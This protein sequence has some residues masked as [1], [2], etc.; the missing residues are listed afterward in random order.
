MTKIFTFC[1]VL[2]GK[3]LYPYQ[4][5]FGKRLVRS[6]IENDGDEITGLMSRQSG[7]CFAKN[8]EILM[9][10]GE[11]KKVQDIVVGDFIMSPHS[12][13]VK[14][15]EVIKGKEE[16]FA[17]VS[18][19]KNHEDFIVNKSHTLSVVD[20]K[21]RVHNFTVEDYLKLPEWK[22][23]YE[24]RGYRVA[25][26]FKE[27]KTPIEPYF[28]GLWL[29]D[30]S[31]YDVKITSVDKEVIDYIYDY[32]D[33]LGMQVSI[34][35]TKT[36]KTCFDYAITNGKDGT[37]STIN[38]IRHYLE[39]NNLLGNKHITK[40]FLLNSRKVRL[41]VLAGLID[42]D[43]HK[44]LCYG[45][46]NVLE[47]TFSNKKL[48]YDV[49]RLIRSLGY[50]ASLKKSKTNKGTYRFR[51]NAY[52]DFSEV[53]IKIPR[54]RFEKTILRE[55]PLTFGFDLVS[56]GKGNYYGFT[57][58]SEDHLFLL[59]DYTVTHNSETIAVV[60]GGLAVIL[61]VLAN[62]PMFAG[63]IR[64]EMFKNGVYI[65]IYA[66]VLNQSQII[67]NRI[68]GIMNSQH[69]QAI[70]QDPSINVWY[71]TN[72]GQNFVLSVGSKITC[73]SASEGSNIEG[74]SHHIIIV[75]ES[76]DVGDMKYSKSISPM[77]AFYN[78]TKIL[79]GTPTTEVGFFYN[80]IER[81]KRAYDLN[82]KKRNHYEYDCDVVIKYN[83]RYAKY[84]D[85]E[86]VRLGEDSDEFLMSYKLKWMLQRG[87]FI[88]TDRLM[89][90]AKE[91]ADF[92]FIDYKKNHVAGLDLGKEND[93][94]VLTILEVDWDHPII[95]EV[96]K[97][98]EVPDFIVYDK[99]VVAWLEIQGDD[100]EDQYPQI[101]DF[102]GNYRIGR[103]VIDS[104][105][106]G[107]P[108]FSRI[109]ANVDYECIPYVFSTPSKSDLVKHFDAELKSNRFHFPAC[110][111]AKD[112]REYRRFIS[113][114][115]SAIKTYSGTNMIVGHGPNKDDH[116][117]Y[118]YS[119]ALACWGAKGD[120]VDKPIM[121]DNPLTKTSKQQKNYYQ[122][123]NAVTARRR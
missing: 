25:V 92:V 105:G 8:T 69:A 54:K 107:S 51:I 31:S 66:P 11:V 19:E 83:P 77:G 38:P 17:V 86:K 6:V 20:R 9:A 84:I 37:R 48:S 63:D 121:E 68:K 87:M 39:S 122:K 12:T 118:L 28:Y 104:T 62:T 74:E 117:D 18:R 40:D 106:L 99:T 88:T 110:P 2:S 56:K 89:K 1:T 46:E 70:L 85:G 94:T 53:P 90:L 73:K 76:Q 114:M 55:N 33:K 5:Q 24:F 113:Q 123:R 47:I 23:K 112:S 119:A 32:A 29:G 58:E 102:L 7:K 108:I 50:R 91:D 78:A 44:S 49:L 67:F 42:S 61:P 93:S 3:D 103:L 115:T 60:A 111:E 26:D 14:V 27:R 4:E 116:D 45:K 16:M 95:V 43:G 22:R 34:Y 21:N 52:G 36:S 80:S 109:A 13:P 97:E 35:K 57:I 59:G 101:M 71:D 65:G 81:N 79:I 30:G 15:T 98:L 64:L 75:D 41:Q 72:N 82:K 120:G 10:D 96:S 100:W